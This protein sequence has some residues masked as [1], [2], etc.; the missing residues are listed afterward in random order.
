MSK[1]HQLETARLSLRQWQDRD[2]DG[3]AKMN[4]DEEVMRYF[5]STLS[6]SQSKTAI[7]KYSTLIAKKGWGFWAA[8]SRENASFIGV[9][10]LHYIDD[11]PIV[12]C[13]EVGWRLA[14]PYWGMGYATEAASRCLEF[15]FG[16]LQ[17][18]EV[19]AI[20]S[21][22]NKKSRAVMERLGM[23]NSGN[24][25][26]HPRVSAESGI[27]EHVLYRITPEQFYN[28]G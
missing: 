16:E 22:N 8:E 15:A 17:L 13:V 2:L 6:R 25:F 3:F 4:T 11:L 28:R 1:I 5:P 19:V 27:Q 10:G 26:L 23:L 12:N 24:N 9:V 7:E 14:R 18:D 20:T 21:I